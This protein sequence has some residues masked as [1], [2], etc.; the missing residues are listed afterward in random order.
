M[1]NDEDIMRIDRIHSKKQEL[2][3]LLSLQL[4][5][6]IGD[7]NRIAI[8]HYLS[9]RCAPLT[10]SQ[11]AENLPVDVSVVSRHLAILRD[12]D[13]LIAQKQGKEVRYAINSHNLIATLR[14]IADAF[15]ACCPDECI[16]M[17]ETQ[18]EPKRALPE[19]RKRRSQ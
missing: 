18:T 13:I 9:E 3:R 6:A 11:I 7:P 17:G 15:E 1:C 16:I 12:A 4:F 10:V 5:K 14:A 2:D 19:K 8:L